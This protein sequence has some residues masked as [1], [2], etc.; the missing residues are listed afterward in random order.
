MHPNV[1]HDIAELCEGVPTSNAHQKLIWAAS[2]LVFGKQLHVAS[3][4]FIAPV[5]ILRVIFVAS[6]ILGHL[7]VVVHVVDLSFLSSSEALDIPLGL[8]RIPLDEV[9]Y[10]VL[11]HLFTCHLLRHLLW[12]LMTEWSLLRIVHRGPHV[13]LLHWVSNLH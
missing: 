10:G 11:I 12:H 8:V 13:R 3:A 1:V 9:D 4:S 7:E 5:L 6:R 2:I